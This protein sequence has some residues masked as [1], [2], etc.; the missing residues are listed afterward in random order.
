MLPTTSAHRL[1]PEWA[2]CGG[3]SLA[4][5]A[6]TLSFWGAARL[7]AILGDRYAAMQHGAGSR[8]IAL[9]LQRVSIAGDP[10]W[11]AAQSGRLYRAVGRRTQSPFPPNCRATFTNWRIRFVG[12]RLFRVALEQVSF[13]SNRG[14]PGP[15]QTT[16]P[17]GTSQPESPTSPEMRSRPR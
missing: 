3:V 1:A 14:V 7:L 15:E 2:A 16:P 4:A 6:V 9:L 13:R 17:V 12:T 11:R 10:S 5:G 8:S